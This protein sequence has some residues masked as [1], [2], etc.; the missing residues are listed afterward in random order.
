MTRKDLEKFESVLGFNL[1]QVEK[2]YLQH[3]ILLFLSRRI[4][5]EF[6]F[7]GGTALQKFYGSNRFS[8]DLDFT[9]VKEINLHKIFKEVA[10]D[11]TIFGSEALVKKRKENLGKTF[12]F[13]IKGPLYTGSERSISTLRLEISLREKV[14]LEPNV[15]EIVPIYTDIP[16]YILP[17]MKPREILAEKVRAIVKRTKARDVYDLWFLIKKGIAVDI[18]LINEK[19]KFYGKTFNIREFYKKLETVKDVWE[20]ELKPL[21]SF[22]PDVNKVILNIKQKFSKVQKVK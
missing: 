20:P 16:P 13:K 6:V 8:I 2:D 19:L 11:L 21:I 9:L 3:L 18:K 17:V 22:A 7:K 14:K 10:M 15:K 5:N 4:K 1:W 12:S